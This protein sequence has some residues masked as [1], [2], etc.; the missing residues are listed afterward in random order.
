MRGGTVVDAVDEL[1]GGTVVDV[2]DELRGGTVVDVVDVVGLVGM[3]MTDWVLT[4][5]TAPGPAEFT[6]RTPT[7]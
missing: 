2:V 3:T 5:A 7:W 1:R 6:A 4:E